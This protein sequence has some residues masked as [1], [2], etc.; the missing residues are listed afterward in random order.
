L[1]RRHLGGISIGKETEMA[2]KKGTL[3][4]GKRAQRLRP[5]AQAQRHKRH[6]HATDAAAVKA[7]LDAEAAREA[8]VEEISLAP[9]VDEPA[10]KK[11]RK[12]GRQ[13]GDASPQA[14][15]ERQEHIKEAMEFRLM[16]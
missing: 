3:A 10:P 2:K 15:V 14:E 1:A 12:P 6:A 11:R 8:D 5:S 13:K 7:V 4:A 16:G 9:K